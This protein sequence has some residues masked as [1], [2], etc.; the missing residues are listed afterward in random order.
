MEVVLL[1]LFFAD[2]HCNDVAF[3]VGFG[4]AVV[5]FEEAW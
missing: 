3:D 5:A 2:P 1:R 4:F